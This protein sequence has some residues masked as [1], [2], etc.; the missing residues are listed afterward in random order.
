[1]QGVVSF[2]QA[3]EDTLSS[4]TVSITILEIAA[5]GAD[6]LVASEVQMCDGLFWMALVRSLSLAPRRGPGERRQF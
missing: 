3:S 2:A 5:I 4:E 1:V 6:L